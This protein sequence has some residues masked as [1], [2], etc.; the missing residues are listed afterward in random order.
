VKRLHGA[1]TVEKMI[2]LLPPELA[3]LMRT[4]G[5][6][7]AGWYPLA[8]LREL[9]RTAQRATGR[10]VELARDIGRESTADD[11]R[12][13]YRVLTFVLS[14]S[15]V[16]KRSPAVFSRYFDTGR[17]EMI[18]ARDGHARARFEGC[19]GFDHNMWVGLVG[20]CAA[21]LEACGGKEVVITIVDGGGE[22]DEH[23]TITATWK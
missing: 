21:V 23:L 22:A 9:Y 12:G 13:I 3:R 18:E 11:F 4:G 17:M 15:F 10:G 2:A 7:T 6:V 14:P 16:L 20:G 1:E 5:F 19:A 8:T